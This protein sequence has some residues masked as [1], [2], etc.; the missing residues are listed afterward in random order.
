[1]EYVIGEPCY[2]H[3]VIGQYE[4]LYGAD[5]AADDMVWRQLLEAQHWALLLCWLKALRKPRCMAL[6]SGLG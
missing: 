1:M 2:V 5:Y 6:G 4:E 3:V